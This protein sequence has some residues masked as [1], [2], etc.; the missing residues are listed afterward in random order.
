MRRSIDFALV[1]GRRRSARAVLARR[2]II[3]ALISSRAVSASPR[4]GLRA[5]PLRSSPGRWKQS[6]TQAAS[7]DEAGQAR[8]VA[9]GILPA[10]E[11]HPAAR[12]CVRIA[13]PRGRM[14][15]L[16]GRQDARRYA[17]A[18]VGARSCGGMKKVHHGGGTSPGGG[19]RRPGKERRQV[20]HDHHQGGQ[21]DADGHQRAQLRR[22]QASHP[23]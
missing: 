12:C 11:R 3:S 14:P 5:S 21:A 1:C 18:G 2:P 8:A 15:R 7:N 22:G 6:T 23:G 19:L 20:D 16:Y 10:V 17:T 4:L 9:A 13:V